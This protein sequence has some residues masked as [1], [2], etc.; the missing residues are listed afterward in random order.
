MMFNRTRRRV[1]GLVV[2]AL[3]GAGVIAGPATPSA[4]AQNGNMV[5]F[6]DSVTADAHSIEYL[7]ARVGLHPNGKSDPARWCP[8]SGNNFGKQAARR[9]GLQPRDYSC[10][11]AVSISRGPNISAQINRAVRERGGLDRGT[12]RVILQTGFNDTY[13]HRGEDPK[14]VRRDYVNY[15]RP[16]VEKIRRAAPNA[17]IQIV[18][19]PTITGGDR[20]CLFHIGPNM[21]DAT[22]MPEVAYWENLAQWMNVDLARATGTQ[23]VDL[24]PGTAKHGMCA[25]DEDREFAGLIDFYAGPGNAPIHVTQRGHNRIAGIVAAS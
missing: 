11:G 13:N 20:V 10:P 24:K 15:M 19:Y 16:Q 4:E 18:G 25:R 21:Y 2:A 22:P 17:R 1:T 12:K 23:F 3:M 6:G 14:K 7:G 8:T 5:I 9:L